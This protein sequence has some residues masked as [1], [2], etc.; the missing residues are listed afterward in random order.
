MT[1]RPLVT[2]LLN[3]YNEEKNIKKCISS[4]IN[5]SYKNW[6]LVV[7][8]DASLDSTVEILKN[9]MIR[10]LDYIEIQK[11]LGLGKK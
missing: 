7:L 11:N 10:E 1:N 5:Q 8:D 2:V 6:E 4:I 9:S 3:C